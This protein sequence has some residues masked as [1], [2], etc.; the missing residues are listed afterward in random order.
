M[1]ATQTSTWT[2]AQIR[3]VIDQVDK[4]TCFLCKW[5]AEDLK[6]HGKLTGW[7]RDYNDKDEFPVTGKIRHLELEKASLDNRRS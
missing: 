2:P 6:L 7:P 1:A 4:S 5:I 3:A